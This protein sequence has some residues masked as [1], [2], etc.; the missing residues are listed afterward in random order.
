MKTLIINFRW[1]LA[2]LVLFTACDPHGEEDLELGPPPTAEDAAISVTVNAENE[3]IIHFKNSSSAF[4]KVWDFGNGS[5]AKGDD[6]TG[7]FPLKGTYEVTLTV[8]TSGGSISSTTTVEIAE[9]NPSMLDIPIYNMLTGGSG[10]TEGKTWVIDAKLP[11]H[12]GVGP[13]DATWPSYYSAPPNDKAGAGLYDDEFT[14]KLSGFSF[15]QS[16]NGDVFINTQQAGSFPGAYENAG[17]FTAPYDAPENLTW[18]ITEDVDGNQFLTISNPGFIGYYTGVSK[19]QILTIEEEKIVLKYLDASTPDLSWFQTLIPLDVANATPPTPSFV[20]AKNG[21]EVSFTN[22]TGDADSYSWDFGDGNNSTE[23]NPVHSYAQA[24]LYTVKL[25]ATNENGSNYTSQMLILATSNKITYSQLT[26]DS[27]K[28][29]RLLPAPGAF[30]VGPFKGSTEWFGSADLSGDRPCLFNDEFIFRSDDR[31]IYDANGDVF[32]EA[33]MG[34]PDGCQ[35]EGDLL[36]TNGEDWR[37][38]SHDFSLQEGV[39]SDPSSITV[40]GTGAFIALPKAYNGGEYN[41]A[42]PFDDA[43][44]TYEVLFYVNDGEN[45]VL[46]I[47]IDVSA[48]QVGGAFWNFI[49]IAE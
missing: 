11:G 45:E 41:S 24:G 9:T 17:D 43:S 3:N 7:A 37:S 25:T 6:V 49:L 38:G 36:G 13:A 26:G 33:Y 30:G 27:Q 46:G 44:V 23:E 47:T 10:N 19:Y 22:N 5:G 4:L 18:S 31:Y 39:G 40:T 21:L 42:P 28:S 34:L 29:W 48:G 14:F 16:T 20:Y 2:L 32:A 35:N 1:I 15:V 12:F 8:Y